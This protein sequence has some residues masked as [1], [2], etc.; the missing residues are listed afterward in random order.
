MNSD[1]DVAGHGWS[2]RC[3]L[4]VM[5]L[6]LVAG[7]VRA[8]TNY[9][10]IGWNNLGMHC[11]DSDYSVFSILPPYNTI[12]AQVIISTSNTVA[13]LLT[14]T[15]GYAVFYSAIGDLTG[16]TNSTAAGKGNYWDYLPYGSVAVNQGLPVPTRSFWMPT[17]GAA[18]AMDYEFTEA[19]FGSTSRWYAA[20]GIPIFPYDDTGM[21]NQYPMMRLALKNN[22]GST[23]KTTDIVLPVSDEMDCKLCHL[24]G[25]GP[26]ARP[27]AGWVN[28]PHPGRDYRLNILRLHDERQ[29]TSNAALYAA[30]LASNACNPAGLYAQV[31][32]DKK[33]FVCATCHK[34]EALPIPQLLGIPPLTTAMHKRHAGV[35][36]PR[37]NQTLDAASNRMACYTCHPGSV[38]RCLRGAMGKAVA[39]DGTLEMQCQ[40]C[41]GA[42]S[43]VG[44]N[45]TGWVDEPTCEACHT[46]DAVSNSGQ[47][48]YTNAFDSP[49]HWRAPSNRR[50]AV[51]LNTPA[52]GASLYRFST[53]HGN[54]QC[55]ACH[56]STHAES[57][58]AFANDNQQNITLQGHAGVIVE[59]NACHYGSPSTSNGGP[60]GLHPVGSNWGHGGAAGS[61]GNACKP[62]HGTDL[63]GTV[64]SR[65][66]HNR[67]TYIKNWDFGGSSTNTYWRGKQI[68]CYE[69][70]DD[71]TTEAGRHTATS[72]R[73]PTVAPASAFTVAGT[74]VTLTP[75]VSAGTLRIV[76]Q[77]ANGTVA[78]SGNTATYTP[79]LGYAGT[80]TFTYAANDGWRDS[81]LATGTVVVTEVFTGHDGIP[82]WWRVAYFP[83][84][85]IT[86]SVNCATCDPDG[87]GQ[88]NLNE[89]LADTN[90]R[91]GRS[92]NRIFTIAPTNGNVRVD[93]TSL[94]GQRFNVE[95]RDDLT[96]GSWSNF[97]GTVWGH[98]DTTSATDTNAAGLPHRFYRVRVL[99]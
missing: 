6:L 2:R 93:F 49:G 13:R 12:H 40:S 38:T 34:S 35:I 36:D 81:N 67:S 72:H 39:A 69:C 98:T 75:T 85:A 32:V 97:T 92:V 84:H 43:D 3:F 28:D 1:H 23:L 10:I 57:P 8:A 21:P 47:I 4:G 9:T 44:G 50:F 42:M 31:V 15:T 20:Y 77:P 41:H 5:I 17:N 29:W 51:N 55:E 79:G 78:L 94:L 82:D 83:G 88:S 64:L 99:P 62:C 16:S 25:S 27:A 46:G 24:S 90:P 33:P 48:R 11:M 45:R 95:R 37:N 65:V 70:H 53:G 89:Y 58:S 52:T 26:A 73:P 60:H 54:L 91:D 61:T 74:S 22:A 71:F 87:D 14:N 56:G 30:A 59:C 19:N 80:D 86:D 66:H 76:S 18:E 63:R 7:P 68:G 96:T